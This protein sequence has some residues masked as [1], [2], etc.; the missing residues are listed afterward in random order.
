MSSWLSL[1]PMDLE[2]L[3]AVP[4]GQPWIPLFHGSDPQC[5]VQDFDLL[6]EP[7]QIM[8]ALPACLSSTTHITVRT[9]RAP[10]DGSFMTSSTAVPGETNSRTLSVKTI[11][12]DTKHTR[13]LMKVKG[14]S[15][16]S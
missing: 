2:L 10:W 14:L 4:T 12:D 8:L 11:V 5:F 15:A 9:L 1:R 16:G 6:F 7:E 13:G 3:L